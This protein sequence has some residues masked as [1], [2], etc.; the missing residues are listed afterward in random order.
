MIL[1]PQQAEALRRILAWHK[2]PNAP[3]RFVLAGYAGAG[4]STLAKMIAGIIAGETGEDVCFAAYTGKAA[5]VLREKGCYNV[6]T[7][8]G[9]LYVKVGEFEPPRFALNDA[10]IFKTAALVIID[11][12]SML[13]EEIIRDIE[14]VSNKVLYLG[15]PFQLPPVSG[16]C[17]LKP[18]YFIEE[19]HR[20]ALESPIIRYSTDVRQGKALA[21]CDHPEFTYQPKN[22]VDPEL[23]EQADQVIV[24]LNKTRVGFN[25]RFREKLGLTGTIY[26]VRG[27][28]L[29]CLKNNHRL[30][31]FNGMIGEATSD[32]RHVGFEELKLDFDGFNGLEVWNGDFKLQTKPPQGI[33]KKFD[34]FDYAYAITCHKSQGSEFDDLLIYS[35]PIGS[36]DTEKRR[37]LYTAITR[38]KKKVTLVQP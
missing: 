23:Y 17:T 13:P 38:G 33:N 20:Q 24:G 16:E 19:I 37:W 2:D 36:N 26:P 18:D 1:S 11:E 21:F 28:K 14:E 5:Q 35:Q 9:S 12:Y 6:N 10:S 32:C 31:L 29:I 3:L 8:H 15:D 30:G 25:A 22:K 4:K 34:R 27:E 7:I